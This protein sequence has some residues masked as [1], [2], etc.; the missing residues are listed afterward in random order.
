[1]ALRDILVHVKLY[2]EWSNHIEVAAALAKDHNARLTGLCTQRDLA[3]LKHMLGADSAAA[4][5]REAKDKATLAALEQKFRALLARHG[6]IGEWQ[7]GE[8]NASELLTLAGRF[9]DLI[10]VEQTDLRRDEAGWDTAERTVL[11]SGKPTLVVPHGYPAGPVG[12]RV[13]VAWNGNREAA[14]AVQAALP[15]LAKASRVTVLEGEGRETFPSLTKV[16]PLDVIAYLARHSVTAARQPLAAAEPNVG[17]AILAQAAALKA[18]LIVM[19]AY[20]RSR[21]HEWMV[22]ST[23]G[24]ILQHTTVPTLMVH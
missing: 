3:L 10:V 6:I 23:T 1:M 7:T 18:D 11:G 24:F 8:G 19:G 9:H 22:G 15:I 16:P 2:E 17:T 12:Q 20:G 4:R 21:L 5:E 13:C 14:L